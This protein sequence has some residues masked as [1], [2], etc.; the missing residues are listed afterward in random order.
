MIPP[1]V[2]HLR[3]LILAEAHSRGVHLEEHLL[4]LERGHPVLHVRLGERILRGCHVSL[5]GD[6]VVAEFGYAP[7][8]ITVHGSGDRSSRSWPRKRNGEF[9]IAAV[10]EHI[11]HLI[12]VELSRPTHE[13]HVER[14]LPARLSGLH[15]VHLA[16]VQL[17][18]LSPSSKPLDLLT[19]VKDEKIRERIEK[20]L[21]KEGLTDADL[22][23]ID[24]VNSFSF[25]RVGKID[26]DPFN[27]WSDRAFPVVLLGRIQGNKIE[28]RHALLVDNRGDVIT[29]ADPAGGGLVKF[30]RDELTVAWHLG[31]KKGVLWLGH[32]WVR[33][34]E[35]AI[36]RMT[37]RTLH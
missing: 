19:N 10:I 36:E 21:D 24:R 26:H 9:N 31:A 37:S 25:G 3:D 8:V 33:R 4:H 20:H 7:D 2:H 12:E 35:P 6:P 34:R 23:A 22:H 1:E 16:L 29:V 18:A 14:S 13:L 27:I 32:L 11:L 30:S 5:P 28:R 15:V 17:G